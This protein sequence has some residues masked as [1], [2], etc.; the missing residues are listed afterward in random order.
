MQMAQTWAL[1]CI[2]GPA[3]PGRAASGANPPQASLLH[4]AASPSPAIATTVPARLAA[5][6][7]TLTSAVG[8]AA[9]LLPLHAWRTTALPALPSVLLT[10]E[11]TTIT[12]MVT[13]TQPG[14]PQYLP[15]MGVLSC[16]L[17]STQL[18]P[19]HLGHPFSGPS[20]SG[21]LEVDLQHQYP[22]LA[23]LRHPHLPRRPRWSFPGVAPA[24]QPPMPIWG[25]WCTADCTRAPAARACLRPCTWPQGRESTTLLAACAAT[26]AVE[27]W[28]MLPM[29]MG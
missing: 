21:R 11:T 4:L 1:I 12:A 17:L 6:P 29:L 16:S 9:A 25:C 19:H 8:P 24:A 3:G 20:S 13:P 22:L 15:R 28:P 27:A 5:H 23:L 7:Q 26:R 2:T 10:M 14:K 18:P